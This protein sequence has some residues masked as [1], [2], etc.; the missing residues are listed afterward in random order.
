MKQQQ[1][2]CMV[3]GHHNM[4]SCVIRNCRIMKAENHCFTETSIFRHGLQKTK[5]GCD[6]SMK[7]IFQ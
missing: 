3:G 5:P 7:L 2:N 1:N 6:N 4:R